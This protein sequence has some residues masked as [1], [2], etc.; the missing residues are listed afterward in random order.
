MNIKN[1]VA[2]PSGL[3]FSC[4]LLTG[5]G[6]GSYVTLLENTDGSV[7]EVFVKNAAGETSINKAYYAASTDADAKETFA[8]SKKQVDKDF[9]A[10]LKA[11][12]ELPVIFLLYFEGGGT[13]LTQESKALLP[14]ITKTIL[15]RKGVDISIIGHS[16]SVGAADMNNKLALK[17]AEQISQLFDAQKLDIKEI[18]ITS[19]GEK[20]QLVKTPDETPEPKN[21]RVSITVR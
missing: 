7:G 18:T 5:C 16:D 9:G 10:A 17:R 6:P 13:E 8:V 20:N 2:S 15:S 14:E 11:Q 4:F 3:L 21:R 1:L 19:H 12:P